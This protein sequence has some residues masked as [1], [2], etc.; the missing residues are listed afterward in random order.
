MTSMYLGLGKRLFGGGAAPSGFRLVDSSTTS[1]GADYSALVPTPCRAGELEVV[2]G[3]E[4]V[5]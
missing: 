2:D 1:S 3:K 5:V 4:A